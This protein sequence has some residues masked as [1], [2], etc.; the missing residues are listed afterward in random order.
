MSQQIDRIVIIGDGL[1]GTNAAQSL[2][3]RGFA[4]SIV[5]LGA[6]EHLPYERPPLSKAVLLGEAEPDSARLHPRDW[7]A[8]QRIDLRTGVRAEAIDRAAKEV[9]LR[10]G[11]RLAYD[12]L[13][14]APG[15][16]PRRL[17]HLEVPGADVRRL[18]TIDDSAALKDRLGGRLLIIGGGWI[19][20]EVAAAARRAGGTVTL[21]VRGELPLAG[22]LG[23]EVAR[24]FAG[25]HREHDVDLRTGT[26]VEEVRHVEDRT[27]ARLSDGEELEVDTILVGIG[28]APDVEPAA[29]AGLAGP[30]GIAVDATLRTVD[31]DICAAGDAALHEHPQLGRIRVD[32]WDAAIEQ[33]KHAAGTLLGGQE[34]YARLPY[35]F[36]DQY[37]L[38]MEY[39]GHVGAEGFDRVHLVGDVPGRVFRAYWVRGESVVAGMH[40]NDWDAIDEVRRLVGGSIA[41]LPAR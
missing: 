10:G 31:P 20:L 21:A 3:E 12:R 8:Q 15:A 5:L 32:H 35:F 14:L 4:G 16:Q 27:R 9:L 19:S 38:G 28:A 37:D 11:E 36:T 41:G 6:E 17:P 25:L 22:V 24:V 39:V 29:A 18:R 13:L 1:A 2:R 33:G 23:D 40:V 34:P 7:Y 30:D 26:T